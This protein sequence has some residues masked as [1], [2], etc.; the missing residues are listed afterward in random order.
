MAIQDVI[1]QVHLPLFVKMLNKYLK[2]SLKEYGFKIYDL[3]LPSK[4]VT[5][6]MH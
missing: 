2:H 4:D 6:H 1:S 3:E 5:L